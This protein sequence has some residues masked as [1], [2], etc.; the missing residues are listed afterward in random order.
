MCAPLAP[1]T[2]CYVE[3]KICLSPCVS[4]EL[5]KSQCVNAQYSLLMGTGGVSSLGTSKHVSFARHLDA[6]LLG[7]YLGVQLLGHRDS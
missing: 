2:S 4:L 3:V 6:F 5:I 1:F 7:N